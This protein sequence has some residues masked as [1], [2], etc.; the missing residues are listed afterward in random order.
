MVSRFGGPLLFAGFFLGGA[1][2]IFVGVADLLTLIH[3]VRTDASMVAIS[4]RDFVGLP[5]GVGLLA[6]SV[7]FIMPYPRDGSPKR[8]PTHQRSWPA[9]CLA[10]L[11]VS[12]VLALAA[13]TIMIVLVG[14]ILEGRNYVACESRSW[15]RPPLVRWASRL[16]AA[17]Q[18]SCAANAADPK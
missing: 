11:A 13:P 2:A 14:S 15:E 4:P 16:S 7:V 8:R 18:A 10:I 17:S 5:L 1:A 9:V 12:L 6:V 3:A